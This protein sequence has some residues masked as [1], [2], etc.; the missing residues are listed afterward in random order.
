[1]NEELPK[2][3]EE[4]NAI[5][6]DAQKSFGQLNAQQLNWKPSANQ[7]SVAQCLEHLIVI[8]SAYFPTIEKIVRNGYKPSLQQ[9]LPLLPRFFAWMVIKAVSP[10]TKAK[11][12]TA[13]HVAPSSSTIA[14]DIV[15]RFKAHQEDLIQ[16]MKMTDKLDLKKITINSPV[17]SVAT[18]SMLNAYR[19]AVTHER[20]HLLQAKRVMEAAGFPK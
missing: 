14:A 19:I 6:G 15:S 7:W 18:Y 5:A 2:L 4:A 20:R 11:F 1:M 17:A 9:R 10:E 12:K 13:G 16:H 3:I 8:N